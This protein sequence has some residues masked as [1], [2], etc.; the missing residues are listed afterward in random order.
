MGKLG[1]IA[2]KVFDRLN[3]YLII[4]AQVIVA[5]MVISITFQVITRYFFNWVAAGMMETWEFGLM[6]IPFLGAAWLLKREGH[7]VMD[8]L[9]RT[10]KSRVQA[11]LNTITSV[12]A[13]IA[14]LVFSWFS[15]AMVIES[16]Q[17]GHRD[18]E[19]VLFMPSWIIIV[20]IP[21]GM[22]LLFIQFLRRAYG[23]SKGARM[24]VREKR[25]LKEQGIEV[26]SQGASDNA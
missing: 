24:E 14:C 13:A 26:N 23:F 8:V 4:V 7:V 11:I 20:I 3:D 21:F 22:A 1:N 12:L 19:S 15:A 6:Y 17:A 2:A 16:Y 5:Y 18:A 10:F 25:L 9:I